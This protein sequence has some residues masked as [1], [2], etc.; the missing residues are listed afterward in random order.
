MGMAGP[1]DAIL[2]HFVGIRDRDER[3]LAGNARHSAREEGIE[4]LL[5]GEMSLHTA[6]RQEHTCNR[7]KAG[8]EY[9]VY[10][11]T[12]SLVQAENNFIVVLSRKNCASHVT[13]RLEMLK[14]TN[15]SRQVIYAKW[16]FSTL[17]PRIAIFRSALLCWCDYFLVGRFSAVRSIMPAREREDYHYHH[18]TENAL[19]SWQT[20]AIPIGI[21]SN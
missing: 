5:Q 3:V 6:T 8:I 1:E 9:L 17:C 21:L 13:N 16:N 4:Q 2:T 12:S 19:V 14:M 7:W 18:H 11:P 10:F 15:P 20:F